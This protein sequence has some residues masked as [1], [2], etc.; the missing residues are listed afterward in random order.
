MDATSS[1]PQGHTWSNYRMEGTM[2]LPLRNGITPDRT[3]S[4]YPY[5]LSSTVRRYVRRYMR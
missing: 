1:V 3:S 5:F 4:D 2:L